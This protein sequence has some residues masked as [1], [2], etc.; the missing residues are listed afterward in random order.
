MMHKRVLLLGA[1]G[2]FGRRIA[3]NLT[4]VPGVE[5]II[6]S[7]KLDKAGAFMRE[8]RTHAPAFPVS[9]MALDRN[10]DLSQAFR[11]AGAW[12]VVDASGPFQGADHRVAL[13][14]LAAGAH[15]FDI[16]DGREYLHAFAGVVD[17]AARAAGLVAL[18][19]VSSTPALSSA[20][21]A[22]LTRGWQRI[23]TIDIAITPD[24][25]GEVGVAAAE[26]V[27]SYAGAPLPQFRYGGMR[28]I[29]GW[30]S[31]KLITVPGLGRRRVAPVD[32]VDAELLSR[33]FNARSRVTFWAGLESPLE[34]LGLRFIAR[35]RH[36]GLVRNL[37]PLA[38]PLARGRALTRLTSGLSG[39]M[40]VDVAGLDAKGRWTFATWS[41]LAEKGLGLNVPGLPVIAATRMLVAGK[42]QPG[43][44]IAC[45]TI[46]LALIE[47]EFALHPI[48]TQRREVRPDCSVYRSVL[49]PAEITRLPGVI[50]L[51]HEGG[52]GPVLRG[53]AVVVRGRHWLARLA[54]RIIGL[55]D[56]ATAVPIHV[57]IERSADGAERW[58]RRFAGK[59]FHS[60]MSLGRDGRMWERFGPLDFQ[61]GLHEAGG[62]LHYPLTA[63]RLFGVPL[64]LFLLPKS[65]AFEFADAHGRFNFDVRLSLPLA[66]LLVHYKG[67]LKPADP[68]SN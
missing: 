58:T 27:L 61:L 5:L 64:P 51:F 60:D 57:S 43:A 67:W 9:A 20:V 25:T 65:E 37:R 46:P 17:P 28:P 40:V 48:T 21:V 66:G 30:M 49:Q 14:A 50:T 62:K 22:A 47:D 11:D 53:E 1:T 18:A 59:A 35:L 63:G 19:G 26:G 56:E 8:V 42:F 31:T 6:T 55:P 23:D 52:L 41:L 38:R 45:K 13:A 4:R 44:R 16:A 32:T 24:G 3:P 10:S 68:C 12:L 15:F 2:N 54:A 29:P 39:G 36:L 34:M 7:R 33:H